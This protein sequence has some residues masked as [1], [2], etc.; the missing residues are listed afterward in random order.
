MDRA[1]GIAV[2]GG[3]VAAGG[4][5][6]ALTSAALIAP[7]GTGTVLGS[8]EETF[9]KLVLA[10]GALGS[11]YVWMHRDEFRSRS[12]RVGPEMIRNGE[13]GLRAVVTF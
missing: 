1:H 2:I 10:G 4:V 11:F 3:A 13:Y 5:L 12:I 7:D 8:D 9:T 6:G